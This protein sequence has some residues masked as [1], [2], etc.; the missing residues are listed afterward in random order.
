MTTDSDKD[1]VQL[2]D[3]LKWRL[4]KADGYIDLKM[5]G[6]AHAELAEIPAKQQGESVVKLIHLRLAM[7]EQDWRLAVTL[8]EEMRDLMPKN[9]GFWIQHAYAKRRAE[10]LD[11]AYGIL[12]E[13][14]RRFPREPVIPY[15]LACYECRLGRQ[16]EALE[17]L[18][19]AF[20]LD[21]AYRETALED[22]DLE[23][24]WDRIS[25]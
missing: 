3:D 5:Y 14:I 19:R 16:N 20:D 11:A 25:S 10:G 9:P 17:F 21:P 13:A 4:Q 15:N 23:P 6:K 18:K 12:K 8:S 2:P 1:A 7:E 22:D 24:L